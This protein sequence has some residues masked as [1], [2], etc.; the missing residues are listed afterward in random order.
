MDGKRITRIESPTDHFDAAAGAQRKINL[1]LGAFLVAQPGEYYFNFSIYDR[2]NS[3]S[4][5]DVGAPRF[6][7]LAH[8]LRVSI[9]GQP[10]ATTPVFMQPGK[11]SCH[12]LRG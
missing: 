4:N 2:H 12:A 1:A 5:S 9:A 10:D 8:A 7:F 6:D 11:W 3:I